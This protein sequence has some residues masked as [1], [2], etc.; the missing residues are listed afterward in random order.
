MEEKS[1]LFKIWKFPKLSET[2]IVN[3]V[4]TAINLGFNVKIL[5][6]DFDDSAQIYYKEIFERYQLRGKIIHENYRIP[7]NRVLR[8]C[9]ALILLI[10]NIK[11]LIKLRAFIKEYARF[12]LRQ[13]F[14]FNFFKSLHS[15]N[16]VHIQY[17]TNAKPLDILK[18]IKFFPPKIIVSF[19][20]H[21]LYFPINGRIP[22]NGYY[23]RLFEKAD[24]L[25]VNTPFLKRKLLELNAPNKKIEIIPVPVNTEFF[26]PHPTK[27]Q[28]GVINLVT[29][30]RLDELKGQVWGLKTIKELVE[31][32]YKVSYTIVGEGV[33]KRFLENE[34]KCMK[35]EKYVVFKGALS[36]TKV[37]KILQRSDIFLMTS[38]TSSNGMQESQGLVTAEAQA[39]GLP[40]VAFDSGGI[41][42]TLKDGY[43]GFLC[44]E[45]DLDCFI[46]KIEHLINNR[47]LR[48]EMSADGIQFIYERF[49]R[50]RIDGEWNKIYRN[51][52]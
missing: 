7:E 32:G 5:V 48:N 37:L 35:I 41:K 31:K 47:E 27:N 6:E 11:Y 15:F 22:N 3:Q 44:P 12:E 45:K 21:D 33:K 40:V 14:M 17:G 18:K 26:K 42:Y 51:L 9:K 4:I 25:I 50:H 20:G 29:V 38:I 1:I 34:V 30:G 19:H 39:C 23:N 10:V 8:Y 49:S 46:S 28:S 2:F 16:V 36:Q 43:S 13:I 52:C 24:K